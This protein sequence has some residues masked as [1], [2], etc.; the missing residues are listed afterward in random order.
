M[1]YALVVFDVGDVI[2]D[3]SWWRRRLHGELAGLCPGLTFDAM[4]RAWEA[5]LV[6]VYE[7]R[8]PYW[9]A[10]ADL[11]AD[12]A[13]P[14]AEHDAVARAAEAA[15]DETPRHRRLFDGVPATLDRLR[16][17]GVKL[18]AL[19]DSQSG[20]AVIR[21]DLD[22]LGVGDRLDAIFSSV[23]LA[24]AKPR[25]QAYL[26]VLERFGVRP[27]TAAFVGHETEELDGAK[28]AGL[29][30]IA[31]NWRT[32]VSADHHADTFPAIADIALATD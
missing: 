19:S 26:A 28:A 14:A 27:D 15:A 13:V 22:A 23:E 25:P 11:L 3:A 29:A 30:T 16:A 24:A 20:A 4:E 12:L 7:G 31:F 5:R 9:D 32:P 17:G 2:Y 6:A 18:A 10:F 21:A 8:R 1:R